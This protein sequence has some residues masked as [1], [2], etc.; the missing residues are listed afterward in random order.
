MTGSMGPLYSMDLAYLIMARIDH[1]ST[2]LIPIGISE[3]TSEDLAGEAIF[4]Q[5]IG[6]YG[7]IFDRRRREWVVVRRL[8]G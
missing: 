7:D 4:D 8:D 2:S 5:A 1:S 3:D 6:N